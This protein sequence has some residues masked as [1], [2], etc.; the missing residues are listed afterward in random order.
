MKT[1]FVVLAVTALACLGAACS[2]CD[3]PHAGNVLQRLIWETEGG[4]DIRFEIEPSGADFT[5]TVQRCNYSE[6]S[7]TIDLTA[8]DGE[9]YPL[10]HDIFHGQ[11]DVHQYTFVPIGPTGTWTS[12]TLVYTDGTQEV[13]ENIQAAGELGILPDFVERHLADSAASRTP[14]GIGSP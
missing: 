12:I 9:V 1:R 11:V 8:A 14:H 13:V 5:I 6:M 4:G 7:Q 10:V 3:D 2:S